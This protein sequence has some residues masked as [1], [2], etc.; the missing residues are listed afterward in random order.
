MDLAVI[1]T[2]PPSVPGIIRECGEER[3]AARHRDFGRFQGDRSR[4]RGARAPDAGR[5]APAADM[6]IIGPNCLGVM[7][8]LTGLNATFATTIARPGNRSASS[9]RAA[10]CAR[11]CWIGACREMVGFSAFVSVGSMLDVGWGDLIYYLGNDP[12]HAQ[13]IVIYM[14]TIGDARSF[15]SA[16]REVA[17]NKPIIVIKA[18]RS[19]RRRQ[20]RR[21]A[22]RL[23]DRQRRGAG[24]RLPA[25]RRAARQQH[26]R[27]VLH[28]RGAVQ[29]AQPQG[30]APDHRDQ[31]RRPRRAGHR[32]AD[33]WAAAS[34][35]R[36]LAGSHGGLQRG[37][38]GHLEPQQ[39][40]R[41]PRRRQPGALRQGAGDRRQRS[42]QRRH[43]GDPD[44]AGHDRSHADRRAAEAARQAGRQAGAGQ[45]DGRRGRGRRRGDPESR[46]HPHL[47]LSRYRRRAPST[48]CG[49]TATTCRVCTRRRPWPTT[50]RSPRPTAP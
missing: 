40:D 5:S 14:E 45:L 24:S 38:A 44:A 21:F 48:T 7:S 41:H 31:R 28:G 43:A 34:W 16:A 46:Q 17:L 42:Q 1:V 9:A 2:P 4:G 20:G 11:P 12:A 13:S 32:R 47:P 29:A 15:L 25:Q 33:A 50:P 23:A 27:P 19:G 18:G 8:P 35:P 26:R 37:P 10:R 30:P 39:S 36:S 22:H 49:S 3:R 6:R